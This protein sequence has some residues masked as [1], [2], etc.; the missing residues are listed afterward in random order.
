MT[1]AWAAGLTDSAGF[2]A[3]EDGF[4]VADR[5]AQ[6]L[7]V[8]VTRILSRPVMDDVRL[9][10]FLHVLLV[11]MLGLRTRPALKA[12]FGYAFHPELM[13][14]ILNV[15]LRRLEERGGPDWGALFRPE[16]PAKYVPLNEEEKPGVY[17]VS[18][19]DAER[20]LWWDLGESTAGGAAVGTKAETGEVKTTRDVKG[21]NDAEAT[22]EV[23][24]GAEV[25]ARKVYSLRLREDNLLRGFDFAKLTPCDPEPDQPRSEKQ[26]ACEERQRQWQQRMA[27]E[28]KRRQS[29]KYA[30][31]RQ[32]EKERWKRE[33]RE[34]AKQNPVDDNVAD[35]AAEVAS[36]STAAVAAA[37]ARE[38]AA[39]IAAEAGQTTAVITAAA[40]TA[41]AAQNAD[42]VVVSTAGSSVSDSVSEA[43]TDDASPEPGPPAEQ[44]P[45]ERAC[46]RDEEGSP[47]AD[48]G[49]AG[50]DYAGV[51]KM[52][53]DAEAAAVKRA[54]PP[55]YTGIYAMFEAK[56]V[57]VASV[58][59]RPD[60]E[61][62]G[63]NG[64]EDAEAAADA[65]EPYSWAANLFEQEDARLRREEE[66]RRR[67]RLDPYFFPAG[68]FENSKLYGF[69]EEEVAEHVQ[70]IDA[71][72]HRETRLGWAAIQNSGFFVFGID[73]DGH[74]RIYVRG[75]RAVP[76][77]YF[78]AKMPEVV[79]R[80][81]GHQV[82][83]IEP[84]LAERTAKADADFQKRMA[85]NQ[86]DSEKIRARLVAS[87]QQARAERKRMAEKKAREAAGWTGAA[88]SEEEVAP[89]AEA[90]LE[91]E[92]VSKTQ[93]ASKIE[94]VKPVDNALQERARKKAVAWMDVPAR[95][96]AP[97]LQPPNTATKGAGAPR[98]RLL[99][100]RADAAAA[101]ECQSGIPSVGPARPP[102]RDG[103]GD[104]DDNDDDS[105][106]RMSDRSS[107]NSVAPTVQPPRSAVSRFVFGS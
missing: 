6:L 77:P 26:N 98:A 78:G 30:Q 73:S 55:D 99:T 33:A 22:A 8:V 40:E 4:A 103:G 84:S 16:F 53:A 1:A 42:W 19:R 92:A 69:D 59:A 79:T 38:L 20:A 29:K 75:A 54:A 82:V 57:A 104:D 100:D 50:P 5:G 27:E 49:V 96:G 66:S 83:Y 87:A 107:G 85:D 45:Q 47:D 61:V 64:L 24:A 94:A 48:A 58:A 76:E 72:L 52:F 81:S 2:E 15:I 7:S 13:V 9:Y 86:N 32:H 60:G 106:E 44:Q 74:H 39:K 80:D 71:V 93:A 12:R 46:V 21:N 51:S 10:E 3:G 63:K 62:A 56:R 43:A 105:W 95:T 37:L 14:P 11:F 65:Y 35:I 91:A 67:L 28:E 31:Q 88:P 102:G 89:N 34:A 17:G 25:L 97:D 70:D 90:V 101:P 18:A 41:E 36:D 68:W 23:Q